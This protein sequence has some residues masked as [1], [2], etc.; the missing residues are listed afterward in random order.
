[1]L[2]WILNLFGGKLGMIPAIFVLVVAGATLVSAI[3][4]FL[5]LLWKVV[6]GEL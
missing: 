2:D 1:M 4:W 5:K 6:N 3:V